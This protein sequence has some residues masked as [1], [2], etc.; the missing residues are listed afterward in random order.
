[1]RLIEL[2]CDKSSFHTL[3]FNREGL[4]LIIGDGSVDKGQEGSSN[5]VGKTLAL[6]LLH[7]CLGANADPR[8]KAAVP[9]WQFHLVFEING[10]QHTIE[11]SG[12]G[13]KV[14]LDGQSLSVGKLRSWLD[15]SGVFHLDPQVPMLSFRSLLKRFARYSREDCLDPLRTA[16]ETDFEARLRTLYLFGM[17]CSLAI[18]KRQ[19]KVDLDAYNK[20]LENWHEDGVLRDVFRAGTQPKMRAEWLER[21]IPRLKADRDRFQVAENYRA[22]ELHAGQLTGRLREI[23][24]SEAILQFQQDSIEKALAQHPDIS[25]D[26]LLQL[27][28][29]LQAIFKPET[30]AHFQAVEDFHRSLSINRRTRL[31]RDKAGLTA[32]AR[33]LA[34]ERERVAEE[35]DRN[36]QSLQGKRALDEYASLAQHIAT[37]EEERQRL[38]DYLNLSKNLQDKIQKIRERRVQEDRDAADY[39]A[40]K[41]EANIDVEFRALA[42]I[43]YPH[44]PAGVVIENN[45]GENQ[46]RYNIAVQIEGHD[47]DGINAARILCLDWVMLMRGA[48][49]TMDF[50][51]HDNRLFA[52]IDPKARAAW[53]SFVVSSLTGT[54][55]QYIASLNTENFN[56]MKEFTTPQVTQT[57]TNAVRLTLRGDRPENKLLGMQFGGA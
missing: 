35:R 45:T 31:E 21:E 40:T 37:L 34:A 3:T 47:S 13:K 49:H 8:L 46:I 6:G 38:G 50:V 5:G 12:D 18:S 22:I 9:D 2:G 23:E 1:M 41:P 55:K 33:D 44:V 26:D 48:N 20:T 57:V 53:F 54:G 19:Q 16:K 17:D 11:R 25:K 4:T 56:A 39:A 52:D 36:L 27:Y 32:K 51:W 30:L 43:L 15:E 28:D 7:H 42:E 10:K 14:V 29:G 24:K